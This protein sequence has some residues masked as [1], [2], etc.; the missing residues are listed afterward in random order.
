MERHFPMAA[1]KRNYPDHFFFLFRTLYISEIYWIVKHRTVLGK[2][3]QQNFGPS[4]VNDQRGAFSEVVPKY[5]GW[6]NRN[7]AFHLT[8]DRKYP[9]F[10]HNGKHPAIPV[11]ASKPDMFA[12]S[13]GPLL[14]SPETFRGCKAIFL[15]H[16]YLKTEKDIRLKRIVSR[17]RLFILRR[18]NHKV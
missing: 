2:I 9:N 8:S 16:V 15:V 3:E 10:W 6:P 7:G 18:S 5:S 11:Q 14:K 17:E 13:R 12:I 1:T 4:S